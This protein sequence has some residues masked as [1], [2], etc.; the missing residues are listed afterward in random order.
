GGDLQ[1]RYVMNFRGSSNTVVAPNK[2]DD[3]D[4]GF[5]TTRVRLHFDGTLYKDW[6]FK[7]LT[8]NDSANNV[9]IEAAWGSCNFGNGWKAVAG[10]FKLPLLHEELVS[11]VRQLAA[12][13]SVV[14]S[15]FTQLRS[16]GAQLGYD[17]T[18]WN[19]K[20]AF[21]DGLASENTDFTNQAIIATGAAAAP[22]II[23]GE[24]DWAVT[25]RFEYKFAGSWD[26]YADFTSKSDDQFAAVLGVAG[27]YQESPNT[28]DPADVDMQTAE[29]TADIQLKSGGWG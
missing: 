14:N 12:E 7:F 19:F 28:S 3:F 13:R 11:S 25:G 29:Y 26:Q 2:G 1:V 27:H 17:T 5:Q 22:F 24:A 8:R 23:R 10:Q 20:V 18:D 4:P 6:G 21:S 15:A 16:Q 9:I